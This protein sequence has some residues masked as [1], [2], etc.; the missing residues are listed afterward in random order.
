MLQSVFI[1]HNHLDKP[2]AR[3]VARRLGAYGISTWLDERELRL[4]SALSPT[5]QK[6]IANCTAVV[7]I[8]TKSAAGSQWVQRELAFAG[9]AEP[10]ISI[11]PVFVEDVRAHPNFTGH[12]GLDASDPHEFERSTQKLAEAIV[13]TPLPPVAK[14]RLQDDLRALSGEV[15]AIRLLIENC[16]NGKGLPYEQ[17]EAVEEVPFHDLDFAINALYDITEGKQ[18]NSVVFVAAHFF[19]RKGV[20]KYTLEEHLAARSESDSVLS[21]AVGRKLAKEEFDSALSLLSRCSPPDDQALAG[22]VNENG[23]ALNSAQR[24]YAARLITFPAREPGGFAADAAFAG[25]RSF[26]ESEDL[27]QLWQRW[28]RNGLFDESHNSDT[29]AYYLGKAVTE[30]LPAW[31][32]IVEDFLYHV[33]RLARSK[34]RSKVFAAVEHLKSASKRDSPLVAQIATQCESALGAAEWDNWQEAE[35]M[36][37]YVESFVHEAFGDQDWAHAYE[38]YRESWKTL[39][40]FKEL[41]DSSA[42]DSGA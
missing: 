22:F 26:P 29:L 3:R 4:G 30:N 1:S 23:A 33:K 16:L 7:V 35:E 32:P 2:I 17:V 6:Q 12:L 19:A 31:Q 42:K 37:I 15:S 13:G 36:S 25:M 40:A 20:G 39:K 14:E 24:S 11:C 18:R 8:A 27:K 10:P 9:A 28:I 38:K 21:L 34:D 41:K 5:I